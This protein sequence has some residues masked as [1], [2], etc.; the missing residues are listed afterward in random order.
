LYN[1]HGI[2]N[3]KKIK[4]AKGIDFDISFWDSKLKISKELLTLE[5]KKFQD[6]IKK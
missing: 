4:K 2:G 3:W 5:G 6:Y 1:G